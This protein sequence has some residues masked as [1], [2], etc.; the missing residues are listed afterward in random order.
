EP[1]IPINSAM[2]PGDAGASFKITQSGSYYLTTNIVGVANK[3]GIHITT[4]GNVTVDLM[5]F[6]LRGIGSSLDGIHISV[7]TT[8]LCVRNGAISGW[9]NGYGVDAALAV[10]A[11]L[12]E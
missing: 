8:N 6:E 1:R 3:H 5:G 9:G 10:N 12:K 4:S 11:L 2:T 7:P